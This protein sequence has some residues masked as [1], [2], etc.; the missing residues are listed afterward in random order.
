MDYDEGKNTG[1]WFFSQ[2][3][4]RE[5]VKFF[6]RIWEK[7]SVIYWNNKQYMAVFFV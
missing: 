1:Y 4:L 6:R 2:S 3:G 5:D 7:Q